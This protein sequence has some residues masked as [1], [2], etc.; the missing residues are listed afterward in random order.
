MTGT[1]NGCSKPARKDAIAAFTWPG[2]S[3][4]PV[5]FG[6]DGVAGWMRPP[7][8]GGAGLPWFPAPV[9]AP[10]GAGEGPGA[11]AGNLPGPP[12]GAGLGGAPAA[13]CGT[14][15]AATAPA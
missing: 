2:M 11:G 12:P 13:G 9:G 14:P 1:T 8:G 5:A 3:K 4:I 6:S 7:F 15:G 10:A